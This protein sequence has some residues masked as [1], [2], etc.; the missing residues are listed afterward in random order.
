MESQTWLIRRESGMRIITWSVWVCLFTLALA[1]WGMAA[2]GNDADEAG[3]KPLFNGINLDGWDG[4]PDLWS[5]QDGVIVGKT[6][7]EKPAEGNTFLVWRQGEVDDFELR[8]SIRILSGNSGVQYRSKEVDKWVIGGYQADFDAPSEWSGILYEEK[9]RGIIARRGQQIHI[10]ADGTLLETGSVGDS[11]EIASKIKKN[12]WNEYRIFVQGNRILHAINGHATVEVVD[13]QVDK[14]SL[15][16]LLA[17]QLH[18]GP[19]M[20][21]QFKDIRLKRLPLKDAKKI[22]LVAGKASHGLGEHDFPAGVYLL[23][24]CLDQVPGVIAADYYEGWPSDP[25][26]FDNANTIL[27]YMDGG[28]GHP[29]IQQDRLSLLDGFMKKGVGLALLHYAVEV[30]KDR[31]GKE[32]LDWIGGYYETGW[33]T[34]PHWTADFK[35]IPKHPITSGLAPFTMNDEWYYNMRFRNNM[36]G[37]VPLL[38][39]T[40]PDNTRGTR[41]AASHPGRPEILSW[42]VERPDGGRGFGFTGGHFHTAWKDENFRKIVLNAALWTAGMEVPEGGVKSTLSEEDFTRKMRTAGN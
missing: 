14:R 8:F 28:S 18:A 16:G 42:A 20:E 10:Q 4:N 24:H 38:I 32:L 22:V 3:F 7:P 5:V 15:S 25:T 27:F 26:A 12:D 21:V 13:D 36:E 33:S 34:N 9:G 2:A 41:E 39:A 29:I 1:S 11:A 40:P 31:G 35:E 6:T 37:V 19:P 17:L 30:P 23:R